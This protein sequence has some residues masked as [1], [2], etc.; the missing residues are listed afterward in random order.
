MSFQTMY[1]G[2]YEERARQVFLLM[3]C[4]TLIHSLSRSSAASDVYKRRVRR[5]GHGKLF[6]DN[7]ASLFLLV[8]PLFTVACARHLMSRFIL[9]TMGAMRKG[10]GT[11][12]YDN[13]ASL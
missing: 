7:G 8:G 5:K 6:Y 12:F 13:G 9:I 4:V 10:H 1:D 3:W 11:L 2:V